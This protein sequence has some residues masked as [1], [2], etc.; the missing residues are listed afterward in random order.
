[1][2]IGQVVARLRRLDPCHARGLETSTFDALQPNYLNLWKS[3]DS[4]K[5]TCVRFHNSMKVRFLCKSDY[6]LKVRFHSEKVSVAL[7]PSC[8]VPGRI[9]EAHRLVYHSA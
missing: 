1:M 4:L 3:L 5:V 8:V 2:H 9:F 7:E 6:T